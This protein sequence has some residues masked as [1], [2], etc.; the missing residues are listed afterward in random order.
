MHLRK[1]YALREKSGMK[2]QGVQLAETIQW[3]EQKRPHWAQR[4]AIGNER[5]V[6]SALDNKIALS[7][8]LE[9]IFEKQ[10]TDPQENDREPRPQREEGLRLSHATHKLLLASSSFCI[11]SLLPVARIWLSGR[12]YVVP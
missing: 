8:L 5:A 7:A 9:A 3:T 1:F 6:Y 12:G 2:N 4:R 11:N 10:W